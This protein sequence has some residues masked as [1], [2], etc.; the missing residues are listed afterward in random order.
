[1]DGPF[2]VDCRHYEY[3]PSMHD[4]GRHNCRRKSWTSTDLVTGKT[5]TG[6]SAYDCALQRIGGD[7][8]FFLDEPCGP[9]GRFF[10]AKD[11]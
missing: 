11:K 5:K 6:Q 4:S 10:E 7:R 8:L 2:C 3:S 9:E 1:M